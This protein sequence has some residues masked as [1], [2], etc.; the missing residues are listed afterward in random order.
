MAAPGLVFR[1]MSAAHAISV[2]SFDGVHAGHASLIRAA[3]D[4]VGP[5]GRITAL[6]FFPHPLTTLRPDSAPPRLTNWDQR[7]DALIHVGADAAERLDPSADLLGQEPR[8]FVE[9]IVATHAPSVWVEGPDFRFGRARSGDVETLRE[10]G[11]EFGFETIVAPVEDVALHDLTIVPA[12]STLARWL[13]SH[14][15][16]AD[17]R[18]VLGRHYEI[19]GEVVQ[20]DQRGRDLGF[21][22]ANIAFESMPPADGVY[23]GLLT[24]PDGRQRAAAISVGTKPTFGDRPRAVEAHVID[25]DGRVEGQS[26]EYGWRTRLTFLAWMREQLTYNEL[27]ELVR[28]IQRDVDQARAI[29][30][31]HRIN[32]QTEAIA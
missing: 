22:T 28:Q 23:A 5:R 1:L 17:V 24:T 26:L 8:E 16:M 32:D 19:V 10:L 30:E 3:R 4:A 7:R 18:C 12:S 29:A 15:R 27:N 21:P 11:R 13:I 14:G 20:G 31:A 6:A 25:W 9:R 2:G